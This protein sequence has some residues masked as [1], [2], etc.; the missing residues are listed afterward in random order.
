MPDYTLDYF[1]I[2]SAD[3]ARS[4]AFFSTVFGWSM[5]DYGGS[6]TEVRDAGLLWGINAD[7]SDKS[8]AA[9]SSRSTSPANKP[10]PLVVDA[11]EGVDAAA[12][13]VGAAVPSRFIRSS[14]CAVVCL[15]S[16]SSCAGR[17]WSRGSFTLS[18][19]T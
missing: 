14:I 10:Q 9:P 11:A 1:E 18:G 5:V 17:A 19:S 16:S 12:T 8:P 3:T 13:W 15:K 2:P 6:Y 7:P 4:R